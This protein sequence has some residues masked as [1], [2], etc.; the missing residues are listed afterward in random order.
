M[1]RKSN[2]KN[3]TY[4]NDNYEVFNVRD[5]DYQCDTFLMAWNSTA[6]PGLDKVLIPV[7]KIVLTQNIPFFESMFREESNWIE[8]REGLDLEFLYAE[9]K[10]ND[11]RINDE[12]QSLEVS[13]D[14]K[15]S[16]QSKTK[17]PNIIDNEPFEKIEHPNG[18]FSF[19]RRI[20]V[21]CKWPDTLGHYLK[22][23]YTGKTDFDDK[24]NDEVDYFLLCDYFQDYKS[25]ELVRS[26]IMKNLNFKNCIGLMK[27]NDR[28]FGAEIEDY[29]KNNDINEY[30]SRDV[31]VTSRFSFCGREF[32]GREY[33]PFIVFQG[34][35]ILAK[36]R[37]NILIDFSLKFFG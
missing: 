6:Q 20:F 30:L 8:S 37:G 3:L 2:L 25:L 32:G 36:K 35:D 24:S 15:L 26:Y 4:R 5:Y 16:T 19:A 18:T 22:S 29:F 7:D 33:S 28:H 31:K 27:L 9:E 13:K 11:L 17:S 34:P 1:D 10:L 12:S 14:E 23:I 21:P